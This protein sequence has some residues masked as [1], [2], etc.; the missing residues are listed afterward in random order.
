[1]ELF[2]W[3]WIEVMFQN[4]VP[5]ELLGVAEHL[6]GVVIVYELFI[7]PFSFPIPTQAVNEQ[8]ITEIKAYRH[9]LPQIRLVRNFLE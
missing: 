3:D 2:L 5:R 7:F 9:E 6:R 4:Y 8:R 1:M